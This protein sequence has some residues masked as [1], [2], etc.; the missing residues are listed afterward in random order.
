MTI[1]V[2]GVIAASELAASAG[3]VVGGADVTGVAGMIPAVVCVA[4][5][6]RIVPPPAIMTI[7]QLS[8]GADSPRE[9]TDDPIDVSIN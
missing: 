6:S 8:K 1:P 3:R 2:G 4:L 9:S 7:V 5:C